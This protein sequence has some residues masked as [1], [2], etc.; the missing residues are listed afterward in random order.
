MEHYHDIN[1]AANKLI[2]NWR[3]FDSSGWHEQPED[4]DDYAH[5]GISN[6]DA[7][8]LTRCNAEVIEE[9]LEKSQDA[10]VENH[11]HWAYG[12]IEVLVIRVRKN[13]R[14]TYAFR[15]WFNEI[16]KPLQEYP[17]LDDMRLSKMERDEWIEQ[18]YEYTPSALYDPEAIYKHMWDYHQ[19]LLQYEKS[20]HLN[21]SEVYRVIDE[22]VK[23]D[24]F[25]DKERLEDAET[26]LKEFLRLAENWQDE[27]GCSMWELYRGTEDFLKETDECILNR[28]YAIIEAPNSVSSEGYS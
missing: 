4:A 18:I 12:W 5:I 20:P 6:R 15:K 23:E 25:R 10:W 9:M 3:K 8:L 28:E 14:I 26:L 2:G 13:G 7:G 16:Q 22:M 1:E 24:F 11:S 19:G 17:C 21:A 27:P